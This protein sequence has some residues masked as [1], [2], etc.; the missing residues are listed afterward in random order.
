MAIN[1]GVMRTIN[2]VYYEVVDMLNIYY[3]SLIQYTNI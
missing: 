2:E 3:R 1:D